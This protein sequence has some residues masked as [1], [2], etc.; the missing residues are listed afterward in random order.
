M[1]DFLEHLERMPRLDAFD[2]EYPRSLLG[3]GLVLKGR[4]FPEQYDVTLVADA[5]AA[6]DRPRREPT[7]VGYL[8]LRHGHFRAEAPDCGG[9]TVYEAWPKGDG[10]FDDDERLQHLTTALLCIDGWRARRGLARPSSTPEAEAAL[11]I[12]AAF[13]RII[14]DERSQG[15]SREA[16]LAGLEIARRGATRSSLSDAPL[17]DVANPLP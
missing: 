3:Y 8:R 1:S 11:R 13:A 10:M 14:T 7:V 2:F 4:A 9:E 6:G 12:A 16:I 17:G 5:D 15:A